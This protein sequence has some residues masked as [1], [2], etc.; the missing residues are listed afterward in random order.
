M[1]TLRNFYVEDKLW[2]EVE[3]KLNRL[4]GK[5][6]KGQNAA[7][8]RVL[9]NQFV[10]TPDDKVNPLLIESIAAEYTFCTKKNKRSNL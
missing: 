10:N 7:L 4:N 8:I 3:E 5:Q 2:K 9:L 6:T 1:K